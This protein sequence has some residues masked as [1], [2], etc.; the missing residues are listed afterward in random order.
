MTDTKD[1]KRIIICALGFD[2]G[3]LEA[4]SRLQLGDAAV[5][6]INCADAADL[7]AS[8]LRLQADAGRG[9]GA[10]L[11]AACSRA[12]Q[13]DVELFVPLMGMTADVEALPALITAWRTDGGDVVIAGRP[14]APGLTGRALR[15]FTG[16]PDIDFLS[17]CKGYSR[18]FLQRIRYYL[19][20]DTIRCDTELLLQAVQL[21]AE[22]RVVP[23]ECR[24]P[25][26]G[27]GGTLAM[28]RAGLGYRLHEWGM[29]CSLKYRRIDSTQYV[30]K[31]GVPYTSHAMALQVV[32]RI[33]PQRILDLGCG[34]GFVARECE[35]RGAEVTGADLVDPE[36]GMM[37]GF[38]RFDLS[39]PE[40]PL[41][42]RQFD[43]ILM[44]DIIEHLAEPEEFLLR[45]KQALAD[46]ERQPL[47]VLSTPNVAFLLVRLNLLLGRFPY[48]ERGILDITHK[49]LFTR[50]SL[51]RALYMCGYEIES[52]K[53]VPV[54]FARVIGSWVGRLLGGFARLATLLLPS[55]FAFQYLVTCR[56]LPPIRLVNRE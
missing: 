29:M 23:V 19:N 27:V 32:E 34:P 33:R 38:C 25:A 28:L 18:G 14:T 44:L 43:M 26:R 56:P 21:R 52:I 17:G 24:P 49:R 54:P 30:D 41:D 42:P 16:R 40:F 3:G 20:S 11:K 7:P 53:A 22:I 39:D 46:A 55:L 36:T 13:E 10:L 5:W 8:W 50:S 2:A 47:I 35:K 9:T 15:W 51:R 1:D 12:L 6:A 31:T 37:T 4:L 48:A 45:L